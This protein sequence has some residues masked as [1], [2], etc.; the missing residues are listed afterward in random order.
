MCTNSD[1][2]TCL[3]DKII[4][5]RQQVCDFIYIIVIFVFVGSL[6]VSRS[7]SIDIISREHRIRR[8]II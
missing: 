7:V 5:A 4:S 2:H 3:L 8:F 1:E 6:E